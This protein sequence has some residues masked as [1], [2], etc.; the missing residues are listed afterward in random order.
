MLSL[1]TKFTL[2][3]A[4]IT[5]VNVI[6]AVMIV[7]TRAMS[8]AYSPW[9]TYVGTRRR[10]KQKLNFPIFKLEFK[11]RHRQPSTPALDR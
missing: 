10:Y 5:V 7:S 8:L 11:K 4:G 3:E 2:S 1:L 9:R 6:T